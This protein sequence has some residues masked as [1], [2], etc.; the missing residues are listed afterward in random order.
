MPFLGRGLNLI[1]VFGADTG[2]CPTSKFK[3]KIKQKLFYN[4]VQN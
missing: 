3:I 4:F 1:T 2:V